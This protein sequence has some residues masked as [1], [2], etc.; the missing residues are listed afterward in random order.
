MRN[1][2]GMVRSQQAQGDREQA[3]AKGDDQRLVDL[4]ADLPPLDA[5]ELASLRQVGE[6][7]AAAIGDRR[8]GAVAL[9]VDPGL[10]RYPEATQADGGGRFV[11]VDLRTAEATGEVVATE[12][13]TQPLTGPGRLLFWARRV[14]VGH[15]RDSTAVT[16]ERMRKLVAL[17]V[18]ASDALS[19]IAYGPEAMLA[20]LVV[21]GAS[22]LSLSLPIAAAIAVLMVTVGLSYRQTIR[23]YRS[24]G[25][26]Y[27]VASDNLGV[28]A[29]LTA[30][31]SLMIDYVM[32]VAVSIASG[33]QAITSAM[34]A[35]RPA[36]V[37]LGVAAIG[38]L[39]AGNLRGVREAGAIFAA[40]TYAYVLAVL[41]LVGV[42]LV[43]AAGRG[44]RPS[45][46][47]DVSATQAVG[48]LLILRAFASGATAMTG[49]EA[50]SNAV[51]AFQPEHW[52]NARTTLTWMITLLVALFAGTVV[53][54]HLDG[55]VPRSDQTVLSQLAHRHL[56]G[57][58]YGYVQAATA[59]VLLLAANTAFNGFPR[60]LFFM[61]RDGYA[62]K[63]FLHMGDRLAFSNGIIA[64]AVV[65]GL[66][67]V[68]FG[69]RTES[70]IHLYAVSVFL[71][72]TLSQAGMVVHW[73][74]NRE[75]HWRKSLTV[76]A[77]GAVLSALVLLIAAV[78]KFTAGAWLVILLLPLIVVTCLRIHRHYQ[79]AD[80]VLRLRPL[81]PEA[82]GRVAL[83][84]PTS[85]TQPPAAGGQETEESPEQLRHLVVVLVASLH[86]PTLRALAYAASLGQPVLAVHLS[87]DQEEADR[88][89]GYWH[90]WG[91]HLRLEIVVSP[92]RAIVAPLARYLQALHQQ[93]PE[94]TLTVIVAETIVGHRR[95]R[96]L[97]T[98]VAGRLRR[99]LRMQP[100]TVISTIPFHLPT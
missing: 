8:P 14:L 70:L 63:A 85:T 68:A 52:R 66:V 83:P 30:G 95:H 20:V 22:A 96:L 81:G 41:L 84:A 32:T 88:F 50:I 7:W 57:P 61:A 56:G 60:L 35:L 33:V 99:V 31:A 62:P 18:L 44:F 67:F 36:S 26:S 47:P 58:L 77:A 89:R 1:G 94:L 4:S 86:R 27:V 29:G 9:P 38:V 97:H 74:R 75:A 59:A 80:D 16:H 5:E 73:W 45:P 72:F 21:A 79:R 64:L 12:Q 48:L 17:P 91:E 51:P 46:P 42:G 78:T 90:A 55:V 82:S 10:H 13:A 15:P 37:I 28:V 3:S 65:A 53:L 39:L 19:S 34:P 54:A 87:P 40:P 25:G 24:A 76:N 92:Y 69:G 6:H 71:A 2:D 49:I 100:E 98:H 43:D 23:A 93:R 11:A